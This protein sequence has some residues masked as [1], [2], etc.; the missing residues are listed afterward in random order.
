MKIKSSV[1]RT[2]FVGV[3]LITLFFV[4][5]MFVALFSTRTASP[6]NKYLTNGDFLRLTKKQ[7]WRLKYVHAVSW[8]NDSKKFIVAGADS[9]NNDAPS[10]YMYGFNVFDPLWSTTTIGGASVDFYP[11]NQFVA[12][13]YF[14]GIEY[15]DVAT[16]RKTKQIDHDFKENGRTCIGRDEI[17]FTQDGSKAITLSSNWDDV[18]TV[19]YIWN[20]ADNEC[21]GA[22][23]KETG[24]AFD[25]ELGSAGH[26]LAIGF[27]N[28]PSGEQGIVE[29]QIHVWNIESRE[30]ICKFKSAPPIAFALDEKIVAGGNLSAEG[31]IDLWDSE[32]CLHLGTL[33]RKEQKLPY[34]MAFNSDE[35]LLAVGGNNAFQIWDVAD[36]KL[37]FESEKLPNAVKILNFSP[38]GRFLLSETDRVT[39]N[40]EAIITLWAINP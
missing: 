31:S 20:T 25:F 22:P 3:I 18:A 10:L 13:P 12:V 6:E 17:R 19:I 24:I 30:L 32:D 9:D 4:G 26:L 14:E 2:V 15:F 34:S 7:E 37:L 29:P 33:F 5:A 38:D 8:A 16:G 21:L 40:D 36:K 23:I 35:N 28:A 11:N 1:R 27:P 39:P